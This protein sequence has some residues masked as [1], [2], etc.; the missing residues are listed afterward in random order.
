MEN[1][2]YAEVFKKM[3]WIRTCLM[4]GLFNGSFHSGY[5]QFTKG[6]T[7]EYSNCTKR[8]HNNRRRAC[9]FV[10]GRSVGEDGVFSN[11]SGEKN[12]HRPA[13]QITRY[14]SCL[15]RTI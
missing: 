7:H 4:A 14:S 8:Y 12:V 13:F 2:L 6:E 5:W 3:S 10:P 15:A 11:S 9:W 1:G